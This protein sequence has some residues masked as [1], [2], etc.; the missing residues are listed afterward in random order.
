M[1]KVEL[2]W[3]EDS[4]SLDSIQPDVYLR[5]LERARQ[6]GPADNVVD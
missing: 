2:R 1:S 4:Q 6:V 5:R 3:L